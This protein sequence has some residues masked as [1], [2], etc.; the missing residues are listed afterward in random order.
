MPVAGA[1]SKATIRCMSLEDG[2]VLAAS[3]AVREVLRLNQAAALRLA[4]RFDQFLHLL[5]DD[6]DAL[7]LK[8]AQQA[9]P[10]AVDEYE[11][12]LSKCCA[13]VESIRC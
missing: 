9:D 1:A 3:K 7:L 4:A 5:T 10:P 8:Y 13:A 6:T 12:Q 2:S 11:A